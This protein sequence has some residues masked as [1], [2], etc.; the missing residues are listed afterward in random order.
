MS[1]F[2]LLLLVLVNISESKM[3][4][5]SFSWETFPIYWH[6][7]NASGAFNETALDILQKF[8]L[9]VIEKGQG[10]LHSHASPFSRK[11]AHP[12]KK[13]HPRNLIINNKQ[14]Q[15]ENGT[16]PGWHAEDYMLQAAKQIKA[17]N[18][19]IHTSFYWN[20]ILDWNMYEM[21]FEF[22]NHSTWHDLVSNGSETA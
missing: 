18:Q 4:W 14:K 19:S 6:A 2:V 13:T 15:G 20:T 9:I 8:P 12:P 10:T 7:C 17:R 11:Y 21:H 16:T 1:A 22:L 5:P 3:Q